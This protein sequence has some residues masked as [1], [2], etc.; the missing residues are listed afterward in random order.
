MQ[1]L[2]PIVE[3]FPAGLM[4]LRAPI[5][6][7]TP[8]PRTGKPSKAPCDHRTGRLASSTKPELF[9]TL[10]EVLTWWKS[11]PNRHGAAGLGVL[12]QRGIVGIDI[13]GAYLPDGVTLKAG[14]AA[15]VAACPAAYWEHSPSG[16]GLRG[17]AYGTVDD[18]TTRTASGDD[19]EVF[20]LE[21][22]GGTAAR[23]LTVTGHRL[24]DSAADLGDASPDALASLEAHRPTKAAPKA[25]GDT[26]TA[27]PINMADLPDAAA[28]ISAE[29]LADLRPDLVGDFLTEA[30]WP[31]HSGSEKFDRSGAVRQVARALR[32]ADLSPPEMLSWLCANPLIWEYALSKRPAERARSFLEKEYVQLAVRTDIAARD[33]DACFEVLA[34]LPPPSVSA[35]VSLHDVHTNP[36]PRRVFVWDGWLAAGTLTL[37]GAAGGTG[38]TNLAQHLAIACARGLDFLGLPTLRGAVLAWF[39][40]DDAPELRRRQSGMV[41]HLG[42]SAEEAA[43]GVYFA[44][45]VGMNNALLVADGSGILRPTEAFK[46]LRAEALRLRPVAIVLDTVAHLFTGNEN[47]RGEVTQFCNLLQGL[48]LETGAAVLLLAHPGKGPDSTWSGST[49]WDGSVRS[50]WF[51]ER[52]DDGVLALSKKKSNYA[53]L[54]DLRI[55]RNDLG[56]FELHN[57]G[58]NDGAKLEE[59]RH[60]LLRE[61]QA[62]NRRKIPVSHAPSARNYLLKQLDISKAQRAPYHDVLTALIDSGALIPDTFLFMD[63][64]RHPKRGLVL[65]GATKVSPVTPAGCAMA[66]EEMEGMNAPE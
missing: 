51:M 38:K 58:V 24:P 29:A 62:C 15:I 61:V 12:M 36:P 52:G 13:D 20:G 8:D 3:S 4:H 56:A 45:R 5:W 31:T 2:T 50:R 7:A 55:V 57:P 23:F 44:S 11:S 32:Y 33:I 63:E 19:G 30:A 18:F 28:L 48:A 1:Y 27:P 42:L 53:A 6:G 25:K 41:T 14:A 21:L 43:E 40:E 17:F 37:L 60:A 9:G 54:G 22:Y 46:A 10:A 59:M 64:Y 49:A 65:G 35:Y 16:K 47:D 34:P 26:P 39:C 66:E